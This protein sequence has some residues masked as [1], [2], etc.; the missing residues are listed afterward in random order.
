VMDNETSLKSVNVPVLDIYGENDLGNVVASAEARE[1][2]I[3]SKKV[4]L[5]KQEMIPGAGHFF[6]GKEQ[7]LI[8]EVTIW[9]NGL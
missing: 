3:E 7:I 9:L 6:D 5:S 4:K 1:K 2:A 8:D